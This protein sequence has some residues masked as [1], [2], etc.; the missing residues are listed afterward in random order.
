[1]RVNNATKNKTLNPWSQFLYSE[2][3]NPD[4][5]INSSLFLV[6]LFGKYWFPQ[7]RCLWISEFRMG[8][9]KNTV[10][11]GRN[12]SYLMH[13]AWELCFVV[14]DTVPICSTLYA[15]HETHQIIIFYKGHIHTMNRNRKKL[16]T[17]MPIQ[18]NS[19]FVFPFFFFF[20]FIF[21]W[22]TMVKV[23]LWYSP[24]KKF[25]RVLFHL[26]LGWIRLNIHIIMN[27]IAIENVKTKATNSRA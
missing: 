18:E 24:L 22:S 17:T 25:V 21:I 27:F 11:C 19:P 5:I 14:D 4:T 7:T 9:P 23:M 10:F 20:F 8:A 13:Y 1:M 12:D 16:C 26:P 3:I 6:I 2:Y 15:V